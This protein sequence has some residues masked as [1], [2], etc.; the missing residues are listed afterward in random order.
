MALEITKRGKP[1]TDGEMIIECVIAVAEEMCAPKSLTTETEF[2]VN[3]AIE[4]LNAL[5]INFDTRFSDLDVIANEIKIFQNPFDPDIEI[6]APE[7]LKCK[8]LIFSAQWH[9]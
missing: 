1:F 9:N 2:P 4:V 5:K 7:I 3:F 8:L 6:L